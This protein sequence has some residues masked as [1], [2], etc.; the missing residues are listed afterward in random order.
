[1]K[2]PLLLGIFLFAGLALAQTATAARWA[3]ADTL[4]GQAR[5]TRILSVGL[6]DKLTQDSQKTDFSKLP[7]A[8]MQET[9]EKLMLSVLSDHLSEFKA[10]LAQLP[11]NKS[12]ALGEQISRDALLQMMHTCP[13]AGP[14]VAQL[15]SQSIESKSELPADERQVL[16]PIAQHACQQISASDAK[17]PLL[18]MSAAQRMK[19]M[20]QSLEDAVLVSEETLTQ[21]Y[22]E[23]AMDKEEQGEE[24]GRKVAL[25]ML[26]ECPSFLVLMGADAVAEEATASS[27]PASPRAPASKKPGVKKP[28]PAR[29]RQLAPTGATHK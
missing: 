17:T 9:F 4:K 1:M 27:Q 20:E 10:L 26:Q 5:F 11:T 19:L 7:A 23:D 28:M 13:A 15:A 3:P 22:G 12:D 25:L 29:K 8:E 6:C 24:L 14:I 2:Q 18:K 21:Y 16:L